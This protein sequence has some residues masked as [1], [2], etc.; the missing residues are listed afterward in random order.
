[1]TPPQSGGFAIEFESMGDL[2][3]KAFYSCERRNWGGKVK[4]ITDLRGCA[5]IFGERACLQLLT[6][7]RPWAGLSDGSHESH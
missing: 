6:S 4:R 1:M 3:V 5:E 7:A 2:H